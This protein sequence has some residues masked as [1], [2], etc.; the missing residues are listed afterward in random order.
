[1]ADISSTQL[2][3]RIGGE[4]EF[5]TTQG[6]KDLAIFSLATDTGWFDRDSGEWRKNLNWHRIV[7]YPPGL[8]ERA[9][10]V[11]GIAKKIAKG[12]EASI[13][14]SWFRHVKQRALKKDF[15][16]ARYSIKPS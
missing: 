5:R 2:L 9:S 3:G 1:M 11:A 8:V 13:T 7:V 15:G 10:Y 6:G 14:A 16:A 4:P 12:E